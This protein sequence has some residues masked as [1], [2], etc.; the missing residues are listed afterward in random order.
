[1]IIK[2]NDT[3]Y[4]VLFIIDLRFF[5]LQ[6]SRSQCIVGNL[7]LTRDEDEKI[8]IFLSVHFSLF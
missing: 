5:L 4:Y 1:M 3:L 2:T 7:L 8:L 6:K